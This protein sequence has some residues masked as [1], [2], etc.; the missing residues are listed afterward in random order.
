M[1]AAFQLHKFGIGQGFVNV[2]RPFDGY[3]VDIAVDD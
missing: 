3:R 2:L 1:P